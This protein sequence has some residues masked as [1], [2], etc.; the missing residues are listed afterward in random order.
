[1][2]IIMSVLRFSFLTTVFNPFLPV[3]STGQH[4]SIGFSHSSLMCVSTSLSLLMSFLSNNRVHWLVC[5]SGNT[6][7]CLPVILYY[8]VY[9]SW[10]LSSNWHWLTSMYQITSA[11]KSLLTDI[12]CSLSIT[13]PLLNNFYQLF[14]IQY[15]FLWVKVSISYCSSQGLLTWSLTVNLLKWTTTY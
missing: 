1:M 5:Q 13:W 8:T 9:I 11:S 7:Q 3:I 15:L 10:S 12:Y 14:A 6:S 2:H 4:L